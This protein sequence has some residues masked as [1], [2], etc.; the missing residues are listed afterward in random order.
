MSEFSDCLVAWQERHGRNDLPWQGNRDPYRIWL[1]EIMLQQ[2]QVGTVVAYY[3]RFLESFPTVEALAAAPEDSVLRHW[4]GLGYYARARNLHRTAREIMV[5]YGGRFPESPES[6]AS[7]PGIGRS[8]AAAI[9]AFAFGHRAAILDG[10]VKRVLARAFGVDGFPGERRVEQ[11]LWLIAESLL[12]ASGIE[13]YTQGLMDLGATLCIRARPRCDS[14]PLSAMCVARREGRTGDLPEARPTRTIPE[15]TATWLIG[16]AGN[17]VLLEKRPPTGIWGGLWC[18]PELNS[19]SDPQVRQVLG[20]QPERVERMQAIR[21]A[22]THFRL[23]AQ[24]LLCEMTDTPGA[25]LQESAGRAWFAVDDALDLAIP[26]PVRR[27]L[28]TLLSP[29]RADRNP[30]ADGEAVPGAPARRRVRGATA[31]SA[32]AGGEVRPAVRSP[33]RRIRNRRQ[34]AAVRRKGARERS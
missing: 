4:A 21:H 17:K 6:L 26:V 28:A 13:R 23:H 14:C 16:R 11:R 31:S 29:D 24:P 33:T 19:E 2:T 10:N 7:L 22:F 20:V 27:L 25:S 15:R 18:F 30:P 1:S 34:G 12:P 8:T 32:A 5:R 3:L 9:A